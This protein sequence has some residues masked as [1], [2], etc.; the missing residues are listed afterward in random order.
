MTIKDQFGKLT[1]EITR[2]QLE[3]FVGRP[4]TD[5]EVFEIDEAFPESAIPEAFAE[6]AEGMD[7]DGDGEEDGDTDGDTPDQ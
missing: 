5:D 2:D 1:V 4:L 3:A 7:D 6:I